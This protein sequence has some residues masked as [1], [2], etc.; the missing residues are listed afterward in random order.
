MKVNTKQYARALLELVAG[1]SEAEAKKIIAS[2]VT[3]LAKQND[4]NKAS[5]LI[6]EVDNAIWHESQGVRAEISS[7]REIDAKLQNMIEEYLK[8]KGDYKNIE[9]SKK[10]DTS[11]IGGFVARYNNRVIDASFKHRLREFRNQLSN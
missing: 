4:L 2:F 5:E 3:Y 1:K 8:Q 11:I 10:I 9:I 7:A 6:K